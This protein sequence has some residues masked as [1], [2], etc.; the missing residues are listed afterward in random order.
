MK[1]TEL[2][3]QLALDHQNVFIGLRHSGAIFYVANWLK[4]KLET[5]ATLKRVAHSDLRTD[6][7]QAWVRICLSTVGKMLVENA[8][9]QLPFV[10]QLVRDPRGRHDIE[11]EILP[12]RPAHIRV[13]IDPTQT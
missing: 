5:C 8:D 10:V 4:R 2:I 12:L 3:E 9:I 6:Q 1:G 13:A 11:G 7:I